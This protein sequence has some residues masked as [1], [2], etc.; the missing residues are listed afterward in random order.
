MISKWNSPIGI[1]REALTVAEQVNFPGLQK[2]I[3]RDGTVCEVWGTDYHI[4][5]Y[6]MDVDVSTGSYMSSS[7][8]SYRPTVKRGEYSHSFGD[9]Y[10]V[11]AWWL[12]ARLSMKALL[13]DAESIVERRREELQQA[14]T[15]VADARSMMDYEEGE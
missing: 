1:A 6:G 5:Q 7:F 14:E 11:R 10:K 3:A 2:E 8:V 9:E 15:A 12:I 4:Q 13:R